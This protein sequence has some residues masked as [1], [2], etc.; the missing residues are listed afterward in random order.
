MGCPC[1]DVAASGFDSCQGYLFND[2]VNPNPVHP[3]YYYGR[4][5]LINVEENVMKWYLFFEAGSCYAEG[6]HVVVFM[7]FYREA[8]AISYHEKL[9]VRH[10]GKEQRYSIV[11][12]MAMSQL[13]VETF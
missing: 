6:E 8:D 13:P 11:Q 5:D 4:I 3:Y 9:K 2:F 1:A 7:E 12:G 10:I